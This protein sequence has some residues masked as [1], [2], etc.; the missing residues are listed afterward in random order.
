MILLGQNLRYRITKS[1]Q[2]YFINVAI[3]H[4]HMAKNCDKLSSHTDTLSTGIVDFNFHLAIRYTCELM[5]L[6]HNQMDASF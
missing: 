5:L 2:G 1:C 3:L 4:T 6:D